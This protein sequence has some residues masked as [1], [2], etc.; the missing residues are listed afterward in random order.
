MPEDHGGTIL[1]PERGDCLLDLA[2]QLQRQD[3]LLG[4]LAARFQHDARLFLTLGVR[5]VG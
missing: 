2:A 4:G 3:L 5:G 1:W